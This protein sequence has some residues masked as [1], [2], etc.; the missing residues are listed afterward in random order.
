ML[1]TGGTGVLGSAIAR[2]L[3]AVH[4][5]R[6]LLLVSR[7]GAAAPGAGA[8]AAELAV[9]GAEATVAA[10]ELED[11]DSV[12]ALLAGIAADRPLRGV[13]HTAGIIDD[14]LV[15]SLTPERLDAVLR[16]KADAAW[17]LHELTAGLGLSAFVLFSSVAGAFGAAGQANYAAANAFLDGLARY[18]RASGLVAHSLAWGL[19][20]QR[21]AMSGTITDHGLSRVSRAGI[22]A[23]STEDGVAL[24]D[25][26]LA[27]D[28][29]VLAPVRLDVAA[30]AGTSGDVPALLR[31]LLPAP[32][33]RV[34][35]AGLDAA[36]TAGAITRRARQDT[37]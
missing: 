10:C 13:I 24:F 6:H 11:R 9:M 31:G 32:A 25:I 1:I 20:E 17:H 36:A 23:F 27:V 15:S 3:V 16:P 21:S 35:R 37:A 26:A 4:Q 22:S 28:E 12:A 34:S 14:G 8:L 33:K 30:I 19:W 2:H 18:R 5:V 7:R 29:P